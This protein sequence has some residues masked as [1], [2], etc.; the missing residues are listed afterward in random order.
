MKAASH[1]GPDY[2]AGL[3][4]F[5][6]TIQSLFNI[7]QKLRLEHYEEILKLHTIESASP[8]WTRSTL[9]HDQVIQ[10]TEAKVRE[11]SDSV[12]CL[13]KMWAQNDSITKWE[14]QVKEFKM[15]A[16]C[17]ELLEIDG[18]A[19]EFEWH[20][21]PGFS[22]FQIFQ[23]SQNDLR[24]RNIEPEKFTDRIVFASMFNDIDWTKRRYSERCISNSEK[25]R[26]TR[27]NSC[28]DTGRSSVL[29]MKRSGTEKLSIL[30][31]KVGFSGVSDGTAIQGSRPPGVHKC[32]CIESWNPENAERKRNQT[33]QC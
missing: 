21:F 20:L 19:I 9:A 12:L 10:R 28:R 13:V 6:N 27:R 33:L 1:L 24:K 15:S 29:E 11:N 7:T 4:V 23:E 16:S 17:Q 2:L 26:H 22:S 8:S 5:K 18:E 25:S 32:Q 3:G 14:G 31:W 30:L